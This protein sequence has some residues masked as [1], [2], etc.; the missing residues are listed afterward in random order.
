MNTP[1]LNHIILTVSDLNRSRAFYRDLLGFH[2]FDV[3][4]ETVEWFYMPVGDLT[5]WFLTHNSIPPGDQF[6][7]FRIGLDH[8]A[9]TAP[10]ET[11]L[12]DLTSK[13]RKAGVETMGVETFFTGNK[14]VVFRD[15]DNIQLEYWMEESGELPQDFQITTGS[16]IRR[17]EFADF[18][19]KAKRVTYASMGDQYKITNPALPDSHQL[20]YSEGPFLYRDIYFGGNYFVGQEVVHHNGTPIWSMAYGGGFWR[21]DIDITAFN[22]IFGEA[23]RLVGPERPYRGPDRYS[24]GDY[25]Y[26]DHTHGG[27][28]RFQGLEGI[29]FKNRP[30]Y[31]LR[32]L[33]GFL[34]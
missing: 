33:G 4:T 31:S 18:L 6:S 10:T 2:T 24:K 7:E 34:K 5:V 22:E 27:I 26:T 3:K 25:E 16:T 17:A 14:Y 32:Y 28:E 19:V 15:P 12:H 11:A 8:L 9:F 29:T 23:L 20:E 13:L 30:I 1:G 21:Q